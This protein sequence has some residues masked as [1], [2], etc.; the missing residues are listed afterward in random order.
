MNSV[1]HMA[2]RRARWKAAPVSDVLIPA[3]V[4]S[5]ALLVMVCDVLAEGSILSQP[6]PYCEQLKRVAAL[7]RT[8]DRFASITGK[9]REGNF[10][11]TSLP[12]TGWKDC[13]IYGIGTYT[14]DS[15]E[16]ATAEAAERAQ[17][18]TLREIKTCLGQTWTE[19]KDRSSPS[20][21]VLHPASGA[22][23]ITLSTDETN[24]KEHVVRL[25]LFIRRN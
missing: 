3:A 14:C 21:V 10:L 6:I 17:A 23:S 1:Q 12:L 16:L 22:V 18:G 15:L 19:A 8:N 25:T 9:P 7:A 11:D 5:A 2:Q 4:L 20:Y 13:S 24:K